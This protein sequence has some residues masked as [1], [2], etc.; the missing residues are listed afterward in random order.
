MCQ[1]PKT[2]HSHF[3]I[4]MKHDGQTLTM[5]QCPKTGHSH[6]YITIKHDVQ[7]LTMCQCP[8]TG[9]SHFYTLEHERQDGTLS[10]V[11]MP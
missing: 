3:Y 2:G 8:K 7:T 9:H 10:I 1:C 11:S 4:T 5:C 6:F